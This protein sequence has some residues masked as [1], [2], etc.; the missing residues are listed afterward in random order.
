MKEKRNKSRGIVYFTHKKTRFG[1]T[2]TAFLLLFHYTSLLKNI[3]NVAFM[4][5]NEKR[6]ELLTLIGMCQSNSS[7]LKN[8]KTMVDFLI[9]YLTKGATEI[10]MGSHPLTKCP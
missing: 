10:V 6:S 3:D 2:L 8:I 4:H 9:L 1:D 7:C 5:Y